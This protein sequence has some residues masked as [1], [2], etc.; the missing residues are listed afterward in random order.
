M[1]TILL[2]LTLMQLD[3][4]VVGWKLDSP[5]PWQYFT[6][7][8]D[9]A[10]RATNVTWCFDGTNKA[11]LSI[12]TNVVTNWVSIST[13]SPVIHPGTETF[14]VYIATMTHQRGDITTNRVLNVIHA[15]TTNSF[16]IAVIG[17]AEPISRSIDLNLYGN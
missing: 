11:A 5:Q 16:P 9:D 6:W 4:S 10:G 8:K 15:G 14:A 3:A 13:T 7:A 12:S 1:N 2:L 17:R